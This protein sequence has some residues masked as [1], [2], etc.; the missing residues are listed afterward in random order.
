MRGAA[1]R[2]HLKPEPRLALGRFLRDK[3]RAT[4]CMDLS[5][6]LSLDLLRMT[7]ASGV[8]AELDAAIPID[9]GATLEQAL[10]GGEDYELL[11]TLRPSTKAP[12]KFEGLPLTKIGRIRAGKPGRVLFDGRPLAPRGYD[13]FRA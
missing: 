10:N 4:A 12:P 11:F 5:D 6:G 8:E 13:H 1:W 2:R 3:L 7:E 9:R